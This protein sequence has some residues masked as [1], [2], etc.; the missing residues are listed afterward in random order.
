MIPKRRKDPH[1]RPCT[2]VGEFRGPEGSIGGEL[3]AA[4]GL[5]VRA[6]IRLPW[7][8]LGGGVGHR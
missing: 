8:M 1:R 6:V 7:P 2:R 4:G 5:A 3:V